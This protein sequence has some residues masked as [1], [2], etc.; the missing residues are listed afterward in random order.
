MIN[1]IFPMR[2]IIRNVKNEGKISVIQVPY[3]LVMINNIQEFAKTQEIIL[4]ANTYQNKK[5]M[6]SNQL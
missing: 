6:T 5:I 1:Y 2:V 3:L 4:L